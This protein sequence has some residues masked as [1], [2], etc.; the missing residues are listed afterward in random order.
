[1]NIEAK[2]PLIFAGFELDAERRQLRREGKNIQLKAKAF[3]VLVFL[4]ENAGRVVAKD[5]ILKAVWEDQFVEE[6]NLAVQISALRKA[7]NDKKDEPRFLVTVPGKGYKFIA[8]IEPY[9]KIVIENP[10]VSGF[11]IER[12]GKEKNEIVKEKTPEN[13]KTPPS[14]FLFS[15]ILIASGLIIVSV[16]IIWFWRKIGGQTTAPKQPKMSLLTTSGKV[17]AV[18]LAPDGRFAVFSQKEPDG[19]SLW[20]R[21]IETGS[22][23]RIAPSRKIEYFGLSISPDGNYVYAS[24]C[25]ENQA[26]PPLWKIPI[27]GGAVEEIPNVVTASAISFSPD[28]KTIAY[29]ESHRPETHL[30]IA[31]ANGANER[32]L[33]RAHRDRRFFPFEQTNPTAWSPDGKSVAVVFQEKN[34]NGSLAGVLLVDSADGNERILVAPKWAFVDH[35][36]WLDAET[37][38][39]TGYD[40]EWSNQIWTVSLKTGELR[41]I[42]NNLQ[43]YR[44]LTASGGNLLTVQVGAVSNIYAADFTEETKALN[45]REI[46]RESGYVSYVG[47]SRSGDIFYSSRTTGKAEIW[48]ID[49][50]G[51]NPVQ[52]TSGANI[53]YGLAVSPA[54]DGFIFPSNQ[55]G[56][57]S[58]QKSDADGR[59]LRSVFDEAEAIFPEVAPD[60]TIV[61]QEGDYKISRLA[62]NEKTSVQIAKG[63]KPSL[64][65][66]GRQTAFF[67][68][69]EG[70]W[71]IHIVETMTG[72]IVKKVD[73]P[74]NV[75][76]RRMRWHPSG[77]FLA[78][79]YNEGENLTLLLLP[80]DGGKARSVENLGK[81]EIDSFAW[82][83]DGRQIIYSV[84]NETQDAVWLGNF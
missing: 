50:N 2:T 20:L 84:T 17:S 6:A 68:M 59:N 46:L 71:R 83:A 39:F 36:A 11:V 79:I 23:T 51:A 72:E 48:R 1:M 78:L 25:L 73:L 74:L 60:G 64:S 47:W 54:D 15:K 9:E 69:D 29:A 53:V 33:L 61:F 75:K 57:I 43:K 12:A 26:S 45:P 52:I 4:A 37:L 58:L 34:A 3:D 31:D 30:M 8:E 35:V 49:K 42:T 16:A 82:S 38:A 27:L 19:E 32:I 70:K 62:P 18:A 44:W 22:Q 10:G 66:D 24:V 14:L 65:P 76:Q 41:Q 28:G 21:Q 13:R 67:L 63:I 80:V 81:G 77:K 7:L 55:N 40:D 56:K 5:E